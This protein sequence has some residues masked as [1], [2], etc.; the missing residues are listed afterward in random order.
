LRTQCAESRRRCR[1]R[2]VRPARS[3]RGLLIDKRVDAAP[4]NV[5]EL[6]LLHSVL[7]LPIRRP[8]AHV[9]VIDDTRMLASN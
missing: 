4:A 5:S 2:L 9:V 3:G 6:F 1:R 7:E 8:C